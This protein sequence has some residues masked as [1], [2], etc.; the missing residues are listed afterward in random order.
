MNFAVDERPT[1]FS[2]FVGN[3]SVVN[4]IKQ[5]LETKTLPN[6]ILFTGNSGLGKSTLKNII[7]NALNVNKKS[8]AFIIIVLFPGKS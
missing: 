6:A 3:E 7:I 4:A 8:L 2:Q 1:D 5:G